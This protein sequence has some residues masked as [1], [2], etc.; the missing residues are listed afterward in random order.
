MSMYELGCGNGRDSVFFGNNGLIVS[1]FD[2]CDSEIEHLNN[3]CKNVNISF[4]AGDF[5][6]LGKRKAVDSIYSRFTLHSVSEKLEKDTLDWAFKTLKPNG[7]LLVE[8]RSVLDELYGKGEPLNTNEFMTSHYRRFV[9]FEPFVQR[10]QKAGFSIIYKIQSKGLAPYKS[11]DPVVIR[12]IAQKR[13]L[14]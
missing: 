5:T 11:E 3:A 10:I 1:A 13:S 4:E 7:I 8:I 2:Q 6:A 14:D 9:E 12:V